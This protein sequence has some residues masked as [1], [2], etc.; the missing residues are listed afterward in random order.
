MNDLSR[1]VRT[2]R[3]TPARSVSRYKQPDCPANSERIQALAERV[4]RDEDDTAIRQADLKAW[5]ESLLRL[6]LWNGRPLYHRQVRR[7]LNCSAADLLEIIAHPWFVRRGK[8]QEYV[9]LSKKGLKAARKLHRAE[10]W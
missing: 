5:R 4:A 3:M 7:E 8:E 1:P 10:Q 6:L 2:V 9:G